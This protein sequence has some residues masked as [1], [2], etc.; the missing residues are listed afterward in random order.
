LFRD[1]QGP[2]DTERKGRLA[3]RSSSRGKTMDDSF[4]T[5]QYLGALEEEVQFLRVTLRKVSGERNRAKADLDKALAM[6][7]S[8]RSLIQ[9]VSHA[10]GLSRI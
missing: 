1:A 7:T 9:P 6:V 10:D 2:A 3:R 5:R 4:D 8:M